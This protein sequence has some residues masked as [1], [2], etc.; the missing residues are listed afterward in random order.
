MSCSK[1][2]LTNTGST[3]TTFNYQRCEDA[4]WVYQAELAPNETKNI[5]LLDDT[6]STAFRQYIVIDNYGPFPFTTP[7]RT[8]NNTPTPTPTNTPTISSTN[9]PTPTPTSTLG[10]AVTQT[11]TPT[12]TPT[13]YRNIIVGNNWLG[14]INSIGG[15]FS[16]YWN[17]SFPMVTLGETGRGFHDPIVVGDQIVVDLVGTSADTFN[18]QIT[19][20]GEFLV[21]QFGAGSFLKIYTSTTNFTEGDV[22]GIVVYAG[23]DIRSAGYSPSSSGGACTNY[24]LGDVSTYYSTSVYDIVIYTNANLTTPAPD[25]Y[26]YWGELYWY[27]VQGG[28]GLVTQVGNC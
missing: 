22:L 12:P 8:P 25:G 7:T 26:Y 27:R 17:F 1:Y 28:S 18:L 6:Y 14:Q 11:S 2:N 20:N 23:A 19:K 4:L 21:N 24:D 10:P 15:D 5:W 13:E 3:I 9:T 16:A